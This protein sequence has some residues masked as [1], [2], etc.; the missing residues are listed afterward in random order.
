MTNAATSKMEICTLGR[1]I[2]L[3]RRLVSGS[4]LRRRVYVYLLG[5]LSPLRL[6]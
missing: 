6:K 2:A 4:L 5:M 1:I 3:R